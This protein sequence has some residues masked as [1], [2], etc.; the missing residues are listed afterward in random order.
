MSDSGRNNEYID[1]KGARR[2]NRRYN[3]EAS[4]GN[5]KPKSARMSV[6]TTEE[7]TAAEEDKTPQEKTT[8]QAKAKKKNLKRRRRKKKV[9]QKKK[10]AAQEKEEAAQEKKEAAK[11]RYPDGLRHKGYTGPSSPVA[12]KHPKDIDDES[13]SDE[14]STVL[15]RKT[16]QT[17]RL[18]NRKDETILKEK[19]DKFREKKLL[20]EQKKKVAAE[21]AKKREEMNSDDAAALDN[22]VS[23]Y[24]AFFRKSLKTVLRNIRNDDDPD[25]REKDMDD[26]ASQVN[27]Y[28][29]NLYPDEGPSATGTLPFEVDPG[30]FI[31]KLIYEPPLTV[32]GEDHTF[33][34]IQEDGT[35]VPFVTMEWVQWALGP[36]I[37]HYALKFGKRLHKLEKQQRAF[38]VPSGDS[39]ADVAPA[40]CLVIFMNGQPAKGIKYRQGEG[41]YCFMYSFAS[42]LHY[43]GQTDE[44]RIIAN[45]AEAVSKMSLVHQ[46]NRLVYLVT[47]KM[48]NIRADSKTHNWKDSTIM[49]LLEAANKE[50][51]MIVIPKPNGKSTTHAFTICIGLVFDSTQLYPLHP[52]PRTFDFV[53]G[54]TGFEK[55]YMTRSFRLV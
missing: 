16:D 9:A 19:R 28:V 12:R 2:K 52:I 4:H 23:N 8:L 5:K 11:L 35:K 13:T 42:A 43:I 29:E 7:T 6:L 20:Q 17:V 44:S 54:S 46:L 24:N 37:L 40:S 10:E 53:S 51:L 38:V 34:V 47:K 30:R 26:A 3:P 32:D 15:K 48:V 45:N 18:E 39:N 33:T 49:E 27:K 1:L 41:N 36:D 55:T 50:Q 14:D 25:L 21:Q 31:Q 22:Q